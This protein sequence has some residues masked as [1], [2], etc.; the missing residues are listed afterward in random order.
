MLCY[1]GV[2]VVWMIIDEIYVEIY[3][4]IYDALPAMLNECDLL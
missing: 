3:G 2:Y 1:Q 4:S